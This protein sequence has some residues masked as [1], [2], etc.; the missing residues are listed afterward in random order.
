MIPF[1]GG[2]DEVTARLTA[3]E[4]EILRDLAGQLIE[5]LA[6]RVGETGSEPTN[7]LLA[8]LGI[9]GGETA[10]LDPA[11]AR[12]LPDAYR[13]DDEAASDH[14]QLT[15]RGLV[16][17]KVE[18]AQLVRASIDSADSPVVVRLDPRGV[19]AWLRT[20][21]DL[22]LTI[23]ARLEI[24]EDGDQ[25][26]ADD[27]SDLAMLAIYDWLGYLQGSLVDVIDV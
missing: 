24:E 26:R 17:R 18:N 3:D 2:P 16:D 12:L 19:Q 22:R 1:S 15:E 10:P 11:L 23:A 25:G 6:D 4:A 5:M 20:L 13:G 27:D 9:G 14:R 8:Q 21:T 7:V